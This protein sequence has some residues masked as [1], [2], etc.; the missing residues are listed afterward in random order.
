[1]QVFFAGLPSCA[2]PGILLPVTLVCEFESRQLD[3][4][5]VPADDQVAR[6]P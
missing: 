2:C 5:S 3:H 4:P 1:V 6:S